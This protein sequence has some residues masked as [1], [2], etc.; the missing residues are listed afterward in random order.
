MT[1]HLEKI[2]ETDAG[3]L[4]SIGFTIFLDVSSLCSSFLQ[5]LILQQLKISHLNKICETN[6]G[7]IKEQD[8]QLTQ[9]SPQVW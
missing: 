7:K 3:L 4:T 6:G 8:V 9:D 5:M 1:R 2:C